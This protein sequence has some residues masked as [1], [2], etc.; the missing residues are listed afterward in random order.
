[1]ANSRRLLV[2]GRYYRYDGLILPLSTDGA[3]I[4]ALLVGIV[5]YGHPS[6]PS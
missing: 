3:V 6:P 2:D 5:P 4:D 1:V